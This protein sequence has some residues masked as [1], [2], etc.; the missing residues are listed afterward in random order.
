M[1]APVIPVFLNTFDPF[2]L[3]ITESFGIRWYGLA[4]LAGFF[5]S[6]VLIAALARRGLTPLTA[7]KAGDF[8]FAV[9]IGTIAGGR[10]GY[11]LFYS[12]ELL[13]HFTSSPPFWGL[14]AINEGGMASHGGMIGIL[15]A[16][17]YFAW[18]RKLSSLHL[19]D[20]IAATCGIG[21]FLGRMANFVNGELV[22]RPCRTAY[23]WCVKFPQDILLWP[24]LEPE[25]LAALGKAASETGVSSSSWTQL[26][27]GFQTQS[28]TWSA[29]EKILQRIIE[30]CWSGNLLVQRALEPLLTLRHPSQV[31]EALLEG[32]VL[33]IVL[34]W[35]WRKPRKPGVVSG[36]FLV[37]YALLRIAG[38]QFR[39][40]DP[41]IGYQLFGLTRGQWLSMALL[42]FG[43]AF[44][45]ACQRRKA[46]PLGG[47]RTKR[48]AD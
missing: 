47:W 38:E 28:S 3:Q 11:C 31:Y 12:P 36:C 30:A 6:Y 32:L 44:L 35:I 2:A 24:S 5:A 46:E 1:T 43:G 7:E 10:L 8:I 25:R 4:Y 29:L 42:V 18:R 26:M 41:Q 45:V 37:L 27:S 19:A 48:T 15:L 23:A 20:L 21:I 16:C 39:M 22:G 34:W 33:T 17:L 9:A 40:P 13:W 14:L